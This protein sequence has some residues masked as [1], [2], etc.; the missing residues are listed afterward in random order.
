[1]R[2]Q[3]SRAKVAASPSARPTYWVDDLGWF[4][5]SLVWRLPGGTPI[6]CSGPIESIADLKLRKEEK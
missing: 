3:A 1:M 6:P 2:A 4:L 5:D